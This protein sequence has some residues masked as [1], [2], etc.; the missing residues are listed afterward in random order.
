MNTGNTKDMLVAGKR[1][2]QVD[3]REGC[4]GYLPSDEQGNTYVA[5]V[6]GWHRGNTVGT[7]STPE[8]AISNFRDQSGATEADMEILTIQNLY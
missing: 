1:V 7:G 6:L 4:G 2:L 3:V 8:E 5:M